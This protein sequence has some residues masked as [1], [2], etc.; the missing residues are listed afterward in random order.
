[1]TD[2]VGGQPKQTAIDPTIK[3]IAI[4]KRKKK[5]IC[6]IPPSRLG[7]SRRPAPTAHRPHT[8]D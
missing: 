1:M 7:D 4:L 3:K 5:E 2:L 6:S 8:P